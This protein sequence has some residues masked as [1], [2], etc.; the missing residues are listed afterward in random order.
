MSSG[1]KYQVF[2]TS[3]DALLAHATA[4]TKFSMKQTT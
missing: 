1:R 4:D 3:G 2:W